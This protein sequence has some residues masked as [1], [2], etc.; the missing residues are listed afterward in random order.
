[1]GGFH[2]PA[3]QFGESTGEMRDSPFPFPFSR[4]HG[5]GCARGFDEVLTSQRFRSGFEIRDWPPGY[6][7]RAIVGI[8]EK[9]KSVM[10]TWEPV[11]RRVGHF[12]SCLGARKM[13]RHVALIVRLLLRV[14]RFG[15]MSCFCLA[16]RNDPV[17]RFWN[18]AHGWG[19]VY[20]REDIVIQS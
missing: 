1:V 10:C 19:N 4:G 15:Q 20:V 17:I 12:A 8:L 3:F 2:F 9:W 7:L 13:M 6:V 18:R 14:V 16:L 11:A 5:E